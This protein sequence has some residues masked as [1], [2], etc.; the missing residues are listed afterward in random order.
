MKRYRKLIIAAIIALIFVGTFVFLWKKGQPKEVVYNEYTPKV[1]NIQK[2][3]IITGK[4]E[5]RNEVNVKPQISGI[6]TELYKEPGDYVNAGDVIAKVKVIPDMGQLSSAEARVRL[7]EINLQQAQVNFNR[8]EN[9]YNQK[10]VSA[11]DYDKVKQS[12]QQAKEEKA[13]AIDALQ[14]VRDGVSQSNAKA[15]STLIRSTISG[16]IL[17]VPVKVGNSVILANT[18]NDGT[19]IATV[20]N[21]NDLI[22]RGNIDETEVGQLVSGMPMK[23]TIGALQDLSFDAALEYISPKAVENNGANQ[24][25]IKAAVKLTEGG[26]IRSGYSAN[27]E[28]VLDKA[29]KVLS[30]PE[31]AIEFSGD[32]TFVYII[33]GSGKQKS[34]ERK[35]VETGLSDG[36]N[37]E[38]KKGVT[39][40]DKVRGPEIIA[41]DNNE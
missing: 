9:L 10:L 25:E 39:T 31:S 12:L 7:A 16:V 13:A 15:S 33:K 22:F 14:V 41:E 19:T 26:K 4:I 23:I 6:I 35:L 5:P 34:Y 18:F 3:T 29:E 11:D 17:D 1:E 32:S 37:I 24:F 30:I 36:V 28:I 8:E 20:A 21:M 2:T 27:A 38:I 40:K